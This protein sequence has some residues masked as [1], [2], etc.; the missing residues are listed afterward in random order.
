MTI[1]S[2]LLVFLFFGLISKCVCQ[3]C[4]I[5]KITCNQN[6]TSITIG[7]DTKFGNTTFNV[8]TGRYDTTYSHGHKIFSNGRFT[9]VTIGYGAQIQRKI[10][11]SLN[12]FNLDLW[13]TLNLYAKRFQNEM[14]IDLNN[15][16]KKSPTLYLKMIKQNQPFISSTIFAG[17]SSHGKPSLYH[18][19][20]SVNVNNNFTCRYLIDTIAAG[21]ELDAIQE[22]LALKETWA[23][24]TV[25]ALLKMLK[26][27]SLARP[28]KV[29][30]PFDLFIIRKN[31]VKEQTY[32][33]Y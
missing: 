2:L 30:L 28:Q 10:A 15:V 25:A 23:A 13:E 22:T 1:K 31:T 8:K 12:T 19:L 29:S 6:D 7:A 3:T 21:G 11:E 33:N 24:G 32:K 17:F 27:E 26:I 18:L 20:F 16:K 9:Y 5:A 4:V 14:A